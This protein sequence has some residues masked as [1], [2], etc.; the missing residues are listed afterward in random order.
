MAKE[1][2]KQGCV[3]VIVL[4]PCFR[5]Y[6]GLLVERTPE[7]K[8]LD[9]D[10]SE[11]PSMT[12]CGQLGIDRT[13]VPVPGEK[14]LYFLYNKYQEEWHLQNDKEEEGRGCSRDTE[15]IVIIPEENIQIHSRSMIIRLDS[16][17][18]PE[19]LRDDDFEKAQKY[20]HRMSHNDI[21]HD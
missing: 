21:F 11:A 15:P 8:M 14:N 16:A 9:L 13:F 17:G 5:K 19:D 3:R 6:H 18:I 2:T 12:A 4:E 7:S 1:I 20:L 10:L